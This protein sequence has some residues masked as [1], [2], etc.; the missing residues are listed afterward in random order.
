MAIALVVASAYMLRYTEIAGGAGTDNALT[1]AQMLTDAVAGPLKTKLQQANTTTKWTNLAADPDISVHVSP[2]SA[3]AVVGF[4]FG[5]PG[6]V[7]TLQLTALAA[8]TAQ[9]EIRFNHSIER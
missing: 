9:V 5:N 6:S 3:P 7:S 8:G 1:R 4:G 2:Y